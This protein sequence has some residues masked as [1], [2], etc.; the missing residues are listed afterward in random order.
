[1][2]KFKCELFEKDAPNTVANWVGLARGVRPARDKSGKWVKKPFYDGLIFHRVI[3]EFMV[4]GGDPTGTGSGNP[5]Y[6][7]PDETNGPHHFD[8]GGMLAMANGGPNTAGSQFFIT[9]VEKKHLDDGGGYGHYQ[10]F[11]QCDNVELVKKMA[12]VEKAAGSP[13]R[14]ATDIVIKKI[15]VARGKK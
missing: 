7:I 12:R 6:K 5:G 4:Q 15:T 2:G 13:E 11:G 1:M 9:E 14:P 3:P 8:K 10:I